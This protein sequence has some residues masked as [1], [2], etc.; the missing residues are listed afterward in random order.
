[1]GSNIHEAAHPCQDIDQASALTLFPQIT[2]I[3]LAGPWE[4]PALPRDVVGNTSTHQH[5]CWFSR[6]FLGSVFSF[7]TCLV[8]SP[9]LPLPLLRP[10]LLFHDGQGKTSVL[11]LGPTPGCRD[12]R[13]ASPA[14]LTAQTFPC[15]LHLPPH[16]QHPF[17]ALMQITGWA[18]ARKCH[19]LVFSSHSKTFR[20]TPQREREREKL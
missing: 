4:S 10:D 11:L 17:P 14:D 3:I 8:L 5:G 18:F 1:M 13:A 6:Q 2:R 15:P 20:E 16:Q 19:V 9:V 7:R 12:H